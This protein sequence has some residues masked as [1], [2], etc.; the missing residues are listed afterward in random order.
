VADY[1]LLLLLLLLLLFTAI[2][3]S[4]GGS[5]KNSLIAVSCKGI[6]GSNNTSLENTVS[7]DIRLLDV[8][9]F[10]ANCKLLCFFT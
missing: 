2:G 5:R 10:S 6:L 4:P 3:L 9:N 7:V 1:L 8:S